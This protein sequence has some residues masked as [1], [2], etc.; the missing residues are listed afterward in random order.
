MHGHLKVKLA[1]LCKRWILLQPSLILVHYVSTPS[2][3]NT[4]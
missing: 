4:L 1:H 2:V 3:W